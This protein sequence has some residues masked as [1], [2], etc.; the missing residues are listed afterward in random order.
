[1]LSSKR[2]R[3]VTSH[4]RGTRCAG[5][6]GRARARGKPGGV[7]GEVNEREEGGR[8]RT[9]TVVEEWGERIGRRGEGFR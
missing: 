3:R 4:T 8:Q 5:G 2:C 9:E 6:S 1:M 7:E